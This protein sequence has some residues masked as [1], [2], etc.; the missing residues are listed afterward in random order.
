M[1]KLQIKLFVLLAMAMATT[2]ANAG[3]VPDGFS[4]DL[5]DATAMGTVMLVAGGAIWAIRKALSFL[6]R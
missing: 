6:G 4:M 1:K 5:A 3:I 2:S